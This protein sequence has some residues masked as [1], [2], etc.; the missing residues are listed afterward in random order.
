MRLLERHLHSSAVP[1]VAVPDVKL[2]KRKIE[3]NALQGR[4]SSKGEEC[5]CG[6]TK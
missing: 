4:E 5:E 3:E 2:Q 6:K 1:Y